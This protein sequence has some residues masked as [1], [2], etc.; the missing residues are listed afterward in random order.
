M[1]SPDARAHELADRLSAVEGRLSAACAAAGRE[2]GDV[3]LVAV[4]KFHPASDVEAL[5]ALGV[6]A[7]GE[8]RDQEARAKAAQVCAVRWHFVGRLQTNKAASV[9]SYA[10]LVES[11][12]RLPLVQAL[13]KGAVRAERE[14]DVLVQVSLDADP[15]RGGAP[16]EQ[17]PE[18]AGA[19]AQAEALRL[20]GLM[21][22]A[23]M[24]ADPDDAF[25]RLAEVAAQVREAHPDAVVL[26]AG[27]SADLEKAVTHGSTIVR[28]GTALLGPRPPAL[29]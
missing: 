26:S 21:A 24:G 3:L 16:V 18:L 7:F 11:C 2:R 14:L 15:E 29:R 25:A 19:V 13:S 23:P 22:V 17:V 9:A 4:T 1:S 6:T 27:M 20:R 28:V 10:S 5:R 8:S 12:D